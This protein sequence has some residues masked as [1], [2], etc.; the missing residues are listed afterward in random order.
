MFQGI[1]AEDRTSFRKLRIREQCEH[2]AEVPRHVRFVEVGDPTGEIKS[3][4]HEWT[5][6]CDCSADRSD[7]ELTSDKRHFTV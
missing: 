2:S 5:F 3:V 7:P 1:N 4:G 6:T